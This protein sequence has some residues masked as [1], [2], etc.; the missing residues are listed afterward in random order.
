MTTL[1]IRRLAAVLAAGCLPA[2]LSTSASDTRPNAFAQKTW[3]RIA[4][5]LAPGRAG[6]S[7]HGQSV[8]HRAAAARRRRPHLDQQCRQPEHID[9]HRRRERLAAPAGRTEDRVSGRPADLVRGR[10]R[11]RHRTGLQRRERLPR[12]AARVSGFGT[13]QQSLER[14]AGSDRHRLGRGQVRVRDHRRDHQRVARQH[15]REHGPRPSSSRTTPIT[16]ATRSRACGFCPLSPASRCRPASRSATGCTSRTFRTTRSACSTISGRDITASVP[17]ARPGGIAGRLQP[18]QHSAA[19]R[20][21]LRR[22]RGGRLGRR[23]TGHR[24]PGARRGTRR[25]LRSRRP[26]RAGVR[27]TPAG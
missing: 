5:E 18:V 7:A 23:G 8:G 26:P 2:C 21:A 4:P 13:G 27:P 17:F 11:Q 25:R 19:G 10:A 6:R 16:D 12:P 3:W 9:V 24:R 1:T 20:T 14:H 22:V 15:G